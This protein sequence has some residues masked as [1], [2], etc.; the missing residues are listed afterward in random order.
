MARTLF[1]C[2]VLRKFSKITNNKP[3]FTRYNIFYNYQYFFFQSALEL[4]RPY[5][6][7]VFSCVT[8]CWKGI[9]YLSKIDDWET[10]EKNNLTIA[11]NNLYINN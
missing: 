1:F 5:F 4:Y 7:T 3:Y 9:N 6:Q 11:L 2:M 10:F 8:I